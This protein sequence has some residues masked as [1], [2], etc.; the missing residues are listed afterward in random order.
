MLALQPKLIRNMLPG[1]HSLHP[2]LLC[3]HYFPPPQTGADLYLLASNHPKVILN[4][5]PGTYSLHPKLVHEAYVVSTFFHPK[6]VPIYTCL[7]SIR[8]WYWTCFLA[9]IPFTLNWR[10][11]PM[12]AC[13]HP[14]QNVIL[15][16][17][18][19]THSLHP[20]LV[21]E[22]YVVTTFFH[23]KPN[24]CPFIHAWP[25]PETDTEHASWHAFLVFPPSWY[26]KPV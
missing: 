19:G 22:A 9:R 6:L 18:P 14:P 24:G 3:R 1:T 16:V 8:N 5:L 17:L 26:R 23:P 4:V 21:H 20:K 15:N 10:T 7:T 12:H 2:K 11:K 25:P 13:F